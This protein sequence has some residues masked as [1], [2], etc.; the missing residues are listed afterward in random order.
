M[1]N[2]FLLFLVLLL[3]TASSTRAQGPGSIPSQLIFQTANRQA[4]VDI[5]RNIPGVI[6]WR[7]LSRHSQIY[8]IQLRDEV[9][10][11]AI[12]A[13]LQRHPGML[14]AQ[15]N[16]VVANRS[17]E[18]TIPDDSDFSNQWALENTGQTG[19]TT[20]ADID[21]PEAWD[22]AIGQTSLFGDSLVVA[23]IDDG[24]DLAHED[25]RFFVHENEIPGNGIDDDG[26]GYIDDVNGWN[27]GSQTG[28]ISLQAHGTHVS[29]I[30]SANTNNQ[31]GV[32]GVAWGARILPIQVQTSTEAEVVAGY[33]YILTQRMLYDQ[34]GGTLGAYVVAT[35]TS[36]GINFG[37]PAN[38]PIWC[39]MYDSLGQHGILSAV[40]TMNIGQ[41]V[42]QVNDVPSACPSP[43]VISVTNTTA[44]DL[45]SNGAAFGDT[46]IDIGAPGSAILSTL[47]NDSYGL[48]TGT[49]MAAPQVAGA[50]LVLHSAPFPAFT[51]QSLADPAKAALLIK[52]FILTGA[53]TLSALQGLVAS[54]GR[55][56]LAGALAKM[57]AFSDTLSPDCLPAFLL[58]SSQ[59]TDSS[60]RL[61]WQAGDSSVAF[62]V[63]YRV[64]GDSLWTDSL[65]TDSTFLTIEGLTACTSYE[66]AVKV[67]C[68]TDSVNYLATATFR[69]EGCCELPANRIG[70]SPNDSSLTFSWSSVFGA[71]AYAYRIRE[72]NGPVVVSGS[73]S[74]TTLMVDSLTSCTEYEWQ[75]ATIC[76]TTDL[77][78]SN[79]LPVRTLGCGVCQDSLYCFSRST[80]TEF[81][82]IE[83]VSLGVTTVTTGND[84]GYR[85]FE[86]PFLP[87][88]RDSVYS[89]TLDPGY[90]QFPFNQWWRVWIDLNQDG[91]F[92]DSLEKVFDSG[93]GVTGQVSG[94]IMLPDSVPTGP[95]RMRV[96][97]KFPGFVSPSGPDACE[98]F[99]GGEVEDYC[100]LMVDSVSA[101]CGSSS[102]TGLTYQALTQELSIQASEVNGADSYQLGISGPGYPSGFS[103][104]TDTASG[105]FILAFAECETYTITLQAICGQIAGGISS[106]ELLTPGC[107]NCQD[108]T[109]CVA[110]GLSSDSLWLEAFDLNGLT[111]QT[112]ND[113]GYIFLEG[114]SLDLTVFDNLTGWLLSDGVGSDSAWVRM[115]IDINA[116]GIWLPEEV[117]VNAYLAVGDSI[118]VGWLVPQNIALDGGRIRITVSDAPIVNSCYSPQQ[119][120]IEELC[121]AGKS[122]GI[123]DRIDLNLEVFPVPFSSQLIIRNPSPHL[124]RK[125][126]LIDMRGKRVYQEFFDN[127]PEAHIHPEGLPEGMYILQVSVGDQLVRRKIVKGD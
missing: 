108:L 32:A 80:D 47:P 58:I 37:D 61:S 79:W 16:H 5:L 73:T 111:L 88:V 28:A 127:V 39:A 95:T 64:A 11:P 45:K 9:A 48:Q 26:N 51:A 27:P 89:I 46:T 72:P 35:N 25:L 102:I 96:S 76:D 124:I 101:L 119:G 75:L 115:W 92:Q 44:A 97:M 116:D 29:G 8:L 112:G 24:F 42:D 43:Y 94:S 41:D 104:P 100:I 22:L 54:G 121:F 1:K 55:L 71:T 38:Y 93:A 12:L 34:S 120:E 20:D 74:D 7:L 98:T 19:G 91:E 31:L 83:S 4:A 86:S 17:L 56:N 107:G 82:W 87:L 69:T 33:D 59:I 109:Y 13:D 6:R 62:M 118:P 15:Y 40:A 60:A 122:V 3:L 113:G 65:A 77:L 99:A 123:P 125:I 81:E 21:A 67:I 50:V 70:K 53:D 49:S 85:F 68:S 57:Q 114:Q 52:D 84:G 78:Y 105:T 14:H 2:Q 23:V 126:E 110:E 36:F 90:M 106:Q 18:A 30:A 63:R 10:G 66:F 103:I 117:V